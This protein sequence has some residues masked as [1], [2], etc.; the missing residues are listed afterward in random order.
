MYD[1]AGLMS[2]RPLLPSSPNLTTGQCMAVDVGRV[3]LSFHPIT[4]CSAFL[5]RC[6]RLALP[7][8]NLAAGQR[9]A[10]VVGQRRAVDVGHLELPACCSLLIPP[11]HQPAWVPCFDPTPGQRRAV[12][13]GHLHCTCLPPFFFIRDPHYTTP[14]STP[15]FSLYRTTGQRVTVDVGHLHCTCLPPFFFIRDP[16]Y[17][18]P[19]STPLFSLYRTTGQR[20]T[21]DV[22]HLH[23][24]CLPA[25]PPFCFIHD[26]HYTTP[27]STPLFSLYLTTGQRVTVDV[28]HLP[29][30]HLSFSFV[31]LTTPHHSPPLCS[32]FTEPQGSAAARDSGRG[33]PAC[34]PPLFF[35]RDPPHHTTPLSTPLLSRYLTTGQRVAVDVGHLQLPACHPP[36]HWCPP[37]TTP[38]STPLLPAVS[39]PST[40][41]Q[42]VAV[43]V[44][45][46]HLPA[47]AMD[48]CFINVASVHLSARVG[49]AAVSLKALGPLC[50]AMAAFK[51]FPKHR[52][53]D[54]SIRR[55]NGPWETLPAVT[56]IALGNANYYGGGMKICPHAN[57]SSGSLDVVTICG[58]TV[59]G[60]ILRGL[61]LF[62]GTHLRFK[63]V[64]NYS[65]EVIEMKVAAA[66]G[67]NKEAS[68]EVY[69]EG[70]GEALGHLPAVF[71]V[72]PGAIDLL[73]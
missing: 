25:L 51:A 73:V 1:D 54:L 62:S 30:C 12:D 13:V 66:E 31:I 27:L 2:T 14:L 20:V 39:L 71:R 67:D 57:P 7:S 37:L 49:R 8:L 68:G 65:A 18:T 64:D 34:L 24:T 40:T 41:G 32:P 29:A 11:P 72:L 48:R 45:H 3:R 16:H 43:D 69:V 17:T 46:L 26:P 21:V 47:C 59:L 44:G 9:V 23:C 56:T 36:F 52:N 61:H 22:G 28:G 10:V 53:V 5:L 35:I 60:F 33:A 50:Y 70:D 6:N 58:Y 63:G 38:L 4:L 55:N 15:L 19:L 42:R